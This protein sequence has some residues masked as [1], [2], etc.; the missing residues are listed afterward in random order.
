MRQE[1]ALHLVDTFAQLV[2]VA[3]ELPTAPLTPLL[4]EVQL[5]QLLAPTTVPVESAFDQTLLVVEAAPPDS[6]TLMARVKVPSTRSVQLLATIL[7]F[8]LGTR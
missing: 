4:L 2:F 6:V 1:Y 7:R 8:V 3:L 5:V